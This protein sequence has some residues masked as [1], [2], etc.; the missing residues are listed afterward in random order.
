MPL[1][2]L[3][4]LT[5]LGPD[6]VA[7]SAAGDELPA[8]A[9]LA[10]IWERTRLPLP[11]PPLLRHRD[12]AAATERAVSSAPDLFR[13]EIV[14]HSVQGRSIAHIWFGHGPLHVLLWSQMHGDEPTA[15]AALFDVLQY[16]RT[17]RQRP[18][19]ARLLDALTL[20]V[21]PMLNPD[22][23]EAPQRRNA[24]G[25]DIN[26]D[27]LRLQTPE[28]RALK[29][30]RDRV[31]PPIGF[32]LHNQNWRTSVGDT[33]QPAAMSLLAVAYDKARSD[34]PRRIRAKKV[35][36]VIRDA[37]EPLAPGMIA[38]YDDE[39][40]E[41]AFGDNLTL[42]GTSVVL[43]ETGPHPDPDP[44]RVLVRMNFVAL[45]TALD[46]LASG[47]V[48]RAD[49]ARY[50]K[51]PFNSS[52]LLH[53]VVRNGNVVTGTGIP[54]FVADIG[55]GASRVVREQSGRR[56]VGLT[57][58]IED[59]GDL[60]VYGALQTIDATGLTVAPLWDRDLEAGET[61]RLP[62]RMPARAVIAVG[63]PASLVLLRPADGGTYV[64][65]RVVRVE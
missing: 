47:S 31:N 41:R 54:P 56:R 2:V 50:E 11:L 36:A 18:H 6:L 20:H 42:W 19:V 9:A 33:G 55:V 44:D 61:V 63:Q 52:N 17:N 49:P 65:E 34:N 40:E 26:R 29:A 58:R 3:L 21:V 7:P 32:N 43:I 62:E 46:A 57:A 10:E 8:P 14:G 4:L 24:Q 37:V 12:V 38:R 39:F 45:L 23:A 30:L 1:R 60:R 27:A 22:G 64:V 25:I 15:T 35:A 48:E 59:L 16:V 28:G 5:L 13:S 51:L 53:T